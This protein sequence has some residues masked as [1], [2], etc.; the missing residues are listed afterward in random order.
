MFSFCYLLPR[1][2]KKNAAT[3]ISYSIFLE[4]MRQSEL[5]SETAGTTERF[6]EMYSLDTNFAV[7]RRSKGITVVVRVLCALLYHT[8]D[9]L[10]IAKQIK[11]LFFCSPPPPPQEISAVICNSNFSAP[12]VFMFSDNLCV[13][14]KH[15]TM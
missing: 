13:V 10:L 14:V 12:S 4:S 7:I 1:V 6:Q 5:K 3:Y 15:L 8:Q 9:K 11:D 2:L